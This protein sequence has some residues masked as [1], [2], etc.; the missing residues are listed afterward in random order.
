MSAYVYSL[1]ALTGRKRNQGRKVVVNGFE[2]GRRA[3][4]ITGLSGGAAL[5]PAGAAAIIFGPLGFIFVF[6]G[7]IAAAFWLLEGRARRGGDLPLYKS[8][9]DKRRWR[10]QI[11]VCWQPIDAQPDIDMIRR[12]S[13]SREQLDAASAP[14]EAIIWGSAARRPRTVHIPGVQA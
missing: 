2:F 9:L 3:L 4:L 7:S 12:S 1:T 11:K 6:A 10:P 8:V 14:R 13:I 5:I